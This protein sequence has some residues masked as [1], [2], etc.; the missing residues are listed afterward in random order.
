MSICAVFSNS[1]RTFATVLNHVNFKIKADVPDE[2]LREIGQLGP[3][4][5]PVFDSL[6]NGVPVVVAAE[7]DVTLLERQARAVFST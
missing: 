1:T 3:R 4:H 2:Q 7:Q 5:S 6:T